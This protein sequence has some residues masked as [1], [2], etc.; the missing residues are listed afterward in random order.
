[1]KN[2][3]RTCLGCREKYDRSL[4]LRVARIIN[5]DGVKAIKYDPEYKLQGRGAWVCKKKECIE[6]VKK[7]RAFERM[8]KAHII[9]NV[10]EELSCVI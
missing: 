8:L 6:K 1:M 7:S 4:L 5:N 3:P 10:Y 2:R 9:D